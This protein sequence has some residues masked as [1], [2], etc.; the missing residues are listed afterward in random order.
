MKPLSVPGGRAAKSEA[1][2]WQMQCRFF[3]INSCSMP[4]AR[5]KGFTQIYDPDFFL[6]FVP[7]SRVWPTFF[8]KLTKSSLFAFWTLSS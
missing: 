3:I 7:P 6:A 4:P 1:E 2:I 5:K 8:A